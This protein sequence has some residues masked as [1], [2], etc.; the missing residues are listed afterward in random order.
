MGGGVWEEQNMW[1]RLDE[2]LKK[3]RWGGGEAE[4][5]SQR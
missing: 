3:P 1:E 4:V 5:G 2:D